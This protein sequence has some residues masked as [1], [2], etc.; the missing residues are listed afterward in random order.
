VDDFRLTNPPTNPE[1]LDALARDFVAHGYDVRHLIR[2]VVASRTYQLSSE[3]NETNRHDER[4]G[5]RALFKRP[6]A[7]ALLDAVCD[8][9]GVPEKFDGL[10]AGSRA[11]QLWDS[12][13][14]HDFLKLFGRPVRATA[15]ECERATQP[16]VAQ[17][18]HVLNSPALHA[19]LSH[20][21][22]RVAKLCEQ[23]AD[24]GELV[25]ELY[26]TVYS[27]FP[28]PEERR[29]VTAFL[30]DNAHRRRTAAEDLTWSLLN[31]TEFLF[32]H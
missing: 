5:S 26:L 30:A 4:N 27:R 15:C 11:V 8:V 3:P 21:G 17:V 14:P 10:P 6:A 7:E 22:G 25:D 13:V 32:N 12:H 31:T 18:L 24:D 16:S 29:A 19:K 9:T 23:N 20:A 28:T 2:T 1:L